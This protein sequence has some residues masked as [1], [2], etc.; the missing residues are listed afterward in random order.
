[1]YAQAG[2]GFLN[3][4]YLSFVR[5]YCGHLPFK[6]RH[7]YSKESIIIYGTGAEGVLG[8]NTVLFLP[9]MV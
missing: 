5:I 1:M 4:Y 8:R 3:R 2:T 9:V 7:K 6:K